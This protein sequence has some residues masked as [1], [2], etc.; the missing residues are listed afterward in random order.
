MGQGHFQTVADALRFATAG[1]A[2]ITLH[3]LKTDAHLTYRIT[4]SEDG[5]V[6]FVKLL[7]DGDRYVYVGLLGEGGLRL[8]RASRLTAGSRPVRA[9]NYFWENARAGRFAPDLD[10]RHEGRCGRCAR[11][12]TTPESLDRGIGPVCAGLMCD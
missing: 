5:K 9:F 7:T 10:V 12:L 1:D 4:E 11:P 3:S 2:V 8:T 6:R